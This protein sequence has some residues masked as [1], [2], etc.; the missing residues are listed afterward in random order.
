MVVVVDGREDPEII[1]PPLSPL[2]KLMVL[3]AGTPPQETVIF[4]GAVIVGSVAGLTVIILDTGVSC[5]PQ[6]SVAVHVSVTVFPQAPGV[7]VNVEGLEVPEI[8][9]SPVNPLLKLMVLGGGNAPQATVMAAGAV[10]AGKA[11]GLTV[12]IRE[13]GARV[14]PQTSV[15]VHVSVTIPPQALGVVENV[16]GFD[17]PEIRQPPVRPLLKLMVLAAGIAPQ[18]T[19]I[20]AGAVIVGSAAGVTVI[21]LETGVSDLPQASVAVQVSVTVPPHASGSAVN[22]ERFDVP[23]REQPP[24]NPLLYGRVLAAGNA[25]QE[26]VIF[27]GLEITGS[28]AGLTVMVLDTGTSC[29]PQASVAVQVSVT[30]PPQGPGVV[31]NVEGLEVPDIRQPPVRPLV[32]LMVLAAGIAPH[33]TVMPAGA[34]IVGSVAGLTVIILDTGESCLPQTSRAIHVSVTVPPQAPGVAVNVDGLEVPEIRQPPVNPLLKLMVLGDG[35]D[36]HATVMAAGAV[37]AGKAA[38]LTMIIRETGARGLPQASVAVHVSVT[39]PP[40]ASGMV[41]NEERF[42]VPDREQLPLNPLLYGRVLAAGNAPQETVIFPGL[43]ITGSVAGLTVMVLDTCT[44]CLPQASVAVQ[45]SVTVPPQGPGVVVNVEGLEVPDIRQPPVRPLVKL[46]V[47]AAGIAPHETV[48]S[49][50][51]AI[52][53]SVAGLT[54]IIL[55]TGDS[56]L[57][58]TSMAVHVSV[59]VPPQAPGVAVNVEG[60]EVPEIRQP[61]VNPLLKLMVLGD[62]TDPHATVMAAGAVIA[63]KAAGLTVIIRETGAR[64]LPQP[65]VAVHVSVTIPPQASGMVE[66]VDG[67]DVPVTRQPPVSPL[68]YGIVLAA[69]M[70]PQSTVI[71]AGA[72]IVGSAAGVTVIVLETGVRDL[73]QASVAVQVSVTVPPQA[74]GSAVYEE[75][76]DVPEMEHPPLNPLL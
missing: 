57:P 25:P 1:H 73:P 72:A 17:V 23:D 21:V 47:L 20:A 35:T 37:I 70:D 49:A 22:E 8:R 26:T 27:P 62:G 19:V 50:G 43:E 4:A 66:N 61:P 55:D 34:A 44:S 10:I 52:V 42:D 59:T 64:G 69:G 32:K 9:Q 45:V 67:L 11:A 6:T 38:G 48:M 36:P 40:Q 18:S 75:R 46:M 71:A 16:D 68:L 74:S 13:T 31:V 33:E 60:L 65:S 51:T 15:A 39:I 41:E 30:V 14:L 53:G 28:V 58:Q 54:V 56:C 12:I 7:P 63:G 29:L 76:F 3:G 5:L 24:L 2:L